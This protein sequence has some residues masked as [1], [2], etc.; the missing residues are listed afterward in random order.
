MKKLTHRI[1]ERRLKVFKCSIR[2]SIKKSKE[3]SK[4][5]KWHLTKKK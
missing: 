4:I 2:Y 1:I 5:Q 3:K